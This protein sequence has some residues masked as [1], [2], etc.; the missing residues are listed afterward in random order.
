VAAD[1]FRYWSALFGGPIPVT[2]SY[3]STAQQQAAYD[4]SVAAGDPDRFAPPGTSWHERGQAVDVN[5]SVI[6]AHPAGTPTQ[7]AVWQR[8]YTAS[9][10]TGWCNP[11]GPGRGDQKEPWH[12]SFRGCG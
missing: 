12:F 7:R 2:D 9:V 8:L 1:A 6:G 3:R 5:L 11:R 10:A 4:K